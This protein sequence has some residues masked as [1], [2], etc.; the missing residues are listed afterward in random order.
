MDDVAS[1][2]IKLSDAKHYASLSSS[3]LL[4]NSL[5]FSVNE[6]FN[7]PKLGRNLNKMTTTNLD[8]QH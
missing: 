4:E 2:T 8:M 5:Y 3:F 6:I 1:P 7:F